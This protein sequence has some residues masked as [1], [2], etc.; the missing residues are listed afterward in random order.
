MQ[1]CRIGG[2]GSSLS[3]MLCAISMLALTGCASG[4]HGMQGRPPNPALLVKVPTTLPPPQSSR[5]EHLVGNH[6]LSAERYQRCAVQL[7]ALIDEVA[8]QAIV[9][10]WLPGWLR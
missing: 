8:P 7:N 1:R 10:P 2:C 9:P 5:M 6:K 3:A 4:P